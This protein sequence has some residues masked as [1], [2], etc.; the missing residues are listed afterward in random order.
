MQHVTA[1]FFA[2]LLLL[3]Y[4]PAP[5]QPPVQ[6]AAGTVVLALPGNAYA[7]LAQEIAQVESLPLAHSWQDA[8]AYNPSVILW[9]AAPTDLSDAAIAAAG[10]ALK[11]HTSL[12]SV[13]ILSGQT[14]SEA[15]QL[16][17]RGQQ[18]RAQ[19]GAGAA[20]FYAANGEHATDGAPS[21][22]L[23]DFQADPPRTLPMDLSGLTDA[24]QQASYLTFTGHG[25]DDYLR[26]DEESKLIAG[27][28]PPLSALVISTGSCQTLRIWSGESIALG[29]VRQ[30]AAAYVGFVYS[31]MAGY[32][33]GQFQDLPFRYT[34]P[35]FPIGQV[36]AL[37]ARGSLQ[38]YANF[39]FYFV[40]GDPRIAL[41]SAPPYRVAS[42]VVA[43]G[44]RT[45]TLQ[46]APRGILP[47]RVPG[48]GKYAYTE[49]PD[50]ASTADGDPFFNARLQAARLGEDRYIIVN[51]SGGDLTLRLRERAPWHWWLTHALLAAFDNMTLFTPLNGGGSIMLVAGALALLATLLRGWR[52][53]RKT[54]RSARPVIAAALAAGCAAALLL[55]LY[56]ALRLPHAAITTKPLS[57]NA[58]WLAGVF[59]LTASGTGLYQLGRS[60]LAKLLGLLV[61][62]TPA[63]LPALFTFAVMGAYNLLIRQQVPASV[64]NYHM[65]AVSLIAAVA[66]GM[67]LAAGLWLG[68]RIMQPARQE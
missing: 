32:L 29:F 22:Q 39:P 53:R 65:G 64:Y 48:G 13:G 51:H 45:L 66:W 7:S 49:I 33:V 62:V 31:P 57:F 44:L 59:L 58:L 23:T 9:V 30:G 63:L 67:L 15:R 52:L 42:D 26:L 54:G 20:V 43:G 25:S 24:L 8:L 40:L 34:W 38:A 17:Q 16:W 6:A 46:D 21:P 56:Q 19:P 35:E 60:R 12:P 36:V 27:D 18:L 2:L 3:A 28:V 10:L 5:A 14:L 37:Q 41:R 68:Q 55:G 1:V 50:L 4:H 11:R 61:A 47:V